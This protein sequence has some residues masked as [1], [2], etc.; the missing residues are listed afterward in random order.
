MLIV[1]SKLA[2]ILISIFPEEFPLT[3][4]SIVFVLS[5]IV[6]TL[7]VVFVFPPDAGPVLHACPE[8]PHING[9][10]LPNVGSFAIGQS[11]F[12]VAIVGVPIWKT[13]HSLAM[14]E[15]VLPLPFIPVVRPPDEGSVAIC[16]ILLPISFVSFAALSDP[17]AF[18]IF[19]PFYP[20]SFIN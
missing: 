10:V 4:A 19:N 2:M 8:I 11:I 17:A 20:I 6:S 15:E 16:F 7:L 18:P 13:V 3:A 1:I 14:L 9:F 12:E 5:I